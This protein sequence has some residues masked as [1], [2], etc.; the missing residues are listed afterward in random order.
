[1][2]KE[3]GGEWNSDV[4]FRCLSTKMGIWVS[5]G[6][7]LAYVTGVSWVD[8]HYWEDCEGTTSTSI[9]WQNVSIFM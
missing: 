8:L 7:E 4:M 1:M 5:L 9:F 2:K 3:R 6:F